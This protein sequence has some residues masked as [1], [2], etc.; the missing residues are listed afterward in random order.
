MHF[1]ETVSDVDMLVAGFSHRDPAVSK[2]I[3]N[4]VNDGIILVTVSPTAADDPVHN[5]IMLSR[6]DKLTSKGLQFMRFDNRVYTYEKEFDPDTISSI[7]DALSLIYQWHK[8]DKK[9]AQMNSIK[10]T[11]S[12]EPFKLRYR[13]GVVGYAVLELFNNL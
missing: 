9:G 7:C 5:Y 12:S 4:W 1:K 8:D 11:K 13:Q 2:I 6:V 10:L 3:R